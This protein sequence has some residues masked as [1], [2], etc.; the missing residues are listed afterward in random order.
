[1]INGHNG[2]LQKKELTELDR[3]LQEIALL[4]WSQFVKLVGEDAIISA[5]ICLLRQADR[6]Y[7]EISQK[8]SITERRAR[9]WCGE[10]EVPKAMA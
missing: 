8:L 6:S 5:K 9:Y 10:C 2:H 7:G 1:M 4:N 3:K